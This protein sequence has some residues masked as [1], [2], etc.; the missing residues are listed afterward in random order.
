MEWGGKKGRKEG[1]R[2]ERKKKGSK[3]YRDVKLG[4]K[5]LQQLTML[6]RE[7]GR[8]RAGKGKWRI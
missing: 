5:S 3:L 4:G 2:Y 1:W 6:M 7:G 8:N